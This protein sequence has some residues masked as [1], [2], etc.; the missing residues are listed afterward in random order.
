MCLIYFES[1]LQKQV[2][3][4]FHYSLKPTGFLMLGIA[5][6]AGEFSNLFT[7]ADRKNNIY[8]KKLIPTPLNFNFATSNYPIAKIAPDKSP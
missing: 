7:L 2:M 3:P 4:I 1:V 6:S 8:T 5:E